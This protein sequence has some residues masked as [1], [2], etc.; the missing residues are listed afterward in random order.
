MPSV[1]V[2]LPPPFKGQNDQ[3]PEF[4]LQNPFCV[5]MSNI[6][7]DRGS[8]MLRKG[9]K[10]FAQQST[11]G[12]AQPL[13]LAAYGDAALFMLVDVGGTLTWYNVTS[14][15]PVSVH[16]T[17]GFGGDDEIHTLFFRDRLFYFGEF[18]LAP[19]SAGPQVYNGSTW[20]AAGYTWP[21]GFIP[22]GGCIHKNRAYFLNRGQARY[23]YSAI[24]AIA[25][26]TTEVD[27]SSLV[28]SRASIVFMRSVSLSENVT[29]ENVLAIGLS[30]G[31]ILVYG[32]SFPNSASWG[33]IARLQTAPL[34][35]I[36]AGIDA[37]G[38][39]F[40]LT[41]NEILSL[42]N[43][44]ARGYDAERREGV[45]AAI[46]NRWKQ[47]TSASLVDYFTR[48]VYDPENDRLIIN[49]SD[50]VDPSTGTVADG[51]FQLVYDFAL[52]TWHEFYQP[53]SAG[54][55]IAASMVYSSIAQFNGGTYVLG[56]CRTTGPTTDRA[57]VFQIDTEANYLDDD[58][59]SGESG[60]PFT[61][62]SAPHPLNRFGVVKTDGLEVIMKSDIYPA[63]DFKL[64]GDL[65]A[66]QTVTQKTSGNGSNVTKTYVNLGIESNL[67]QYEITGTSTSSTTGI[68]IYGTNL[69]VNPS[70]GVAR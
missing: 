63:I 51:A 31:E 10:R 9:N 66:Q 14:G 19:G 12:T 38:D 29:Q 56:R 15:V 44:I 46:E 53:K 17:P 21:V 39:T 16:T 26:A 59:I 45:G 62:K 40:L 34:I 50:Y 13:N 32:G 64:I 27:L 57:T 49:F 2:P 24:D 58:H 28:S 48:G 36:N 54:D 70:Q 65:G 33:L 18:G 3:L 37:K 43:L 68:E 1:G 35:Y 8:L 20:A 55:S 5:R 11:A 4:S 41:T 69:W 22:F 7:P 67:V 52:G 6:K 23:A 47:I 61:L 25:G 42:R 60:I 30:N